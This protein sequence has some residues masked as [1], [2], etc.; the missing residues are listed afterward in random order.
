MAKRSFE[1]AEN[2]A[3][4]S[5]NDARLGKVAIEGA[6]ARIENARPYSLNQSQAAIDVLQKSKSDKVFA[7]GFC[8]PAVMLPVSAKGEKVLW[9]HGIIDVFDL[10]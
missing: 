2:V 7:A 9:Q 10:P 4:W 1:N 6:L 8:G 5:D 3:Q